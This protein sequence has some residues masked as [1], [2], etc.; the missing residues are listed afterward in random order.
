[1]TYETLPVQPQFIVEEEPVLQENRIEFESGDSMTWP[2]HHLAV[3]SWW[4]NFAVSTA[5]EREQ[6]EAFLNHHQGAL[7]PFEHEI[8]GNNP[9][10]RPWFGP[11]VEKKGGG[12][13]GSRS[14]YLALSYSDGTYETPVS[15]SP[16]SASLAATETIIATCDPFPHNVDRAYVYV[17]TST[18]ALKKQTPAI[19]VPED[20][21]AEPATGYDTGGDAPQTENAFSETVLLY[22]S[23]DS[24]E[25]TKLQFN[26]WGIR[27]RML[28]RW[29]A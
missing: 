14:L 25:V 16:V 15:F 5:A 20:G 2:Q 12:S 24:M 21:W 18:S 22:A 10:P 9:L 8:A 3:R 26:A 19:T 28:E 29:A 23:E 13:T 6:L 7:T 17:G 11:T 4:F 1:M 27:V